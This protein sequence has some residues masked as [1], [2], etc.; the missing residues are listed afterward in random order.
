MIGNAIDT[1][2]LS[3]KLHIVP[4]DTLV[5]VVDD[6][7]TTRRLVALIS[8]KRCNSAENNLLASSPTK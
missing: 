6:Y 2:T 7:D 5:T 4:V 1:D 8:Y 3:R